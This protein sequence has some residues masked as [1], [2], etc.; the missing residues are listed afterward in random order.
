[1]RL[2]ASDQEDADEIERP[3]FRNTILRWIRAK[4]LKKCFNIRLPWLLTN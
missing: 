1:M 3:G 2:R 4:L